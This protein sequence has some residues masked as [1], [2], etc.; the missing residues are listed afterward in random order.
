[1]R[2]LVM[3]AGARFLA[4]IDVFAQAWVIRLVRGKGE[5]LMAGTQAFR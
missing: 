3:D 1:M 5:R 4:D 2:E